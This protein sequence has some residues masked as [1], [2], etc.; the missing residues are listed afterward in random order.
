[1]K[2]ERTIL[3]AIVFAGFAT[4]AVAIWLLRP[5]F[6]GWFNHS[7]YYWVQVRGLLQDG[8]LP[9]ADLPFLFH[10]YRGVAALYHLLGLEIASAIVNSTRSVMSI[11]PALIAIPAYGLIKGI[12]QDRPLTFRLWTLVAVSAFLPLTFSHM[13][14]LLQKN[15]L[16]LFFLGGLLF[17]TLR[18]LRLRS[19]RSLIACLA[20]FLLIAVTHLGTLAVTLLFVL[21][22]VSAFLF[23]KANPRQIAGWLGLL[24]VCSGSG[25][26]AVYLLDA[27]AFQRILLYARSSLPGSLI[28]NLFSSDPLVRRPMAFLGIIIPLGMCLFLLWVYRKRRS[29]LAMPDRIFWLGS[30]LFAYILVLPLFDLDLVPR[31]I[32]FLPLPAMVILN[33]CLRFQAK[34]RL[35]IVLVVLASVGTA[36]MV[37]GETMELLFRSPDKRAI[38]REL[39]DLKDQ[40]QLTENDF[41]L[42]R[43]GVNPICNWFLGTKSGLITAVHRDD[44]E[45][46]DRFFVLNPA[47]GSMASAPTRSGDGTGPVLPSQ[48]KAYV[49]MRSDVPLPVGIRPLVETEHLSFY[50]L[51]SMPETWQFDGDGNWMATIPDSGQPTRSDND[52]QLAR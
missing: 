24:L 11:V 43:Y 45:S 27:G 1:M 40:Y 29:S 31:F 20:L 48:K 36:V 21:A 32:L 42:T 51:R 10:L 52:S 12:H 5:E 37:A 4:R 30:T 47:R 26:I 9:Y 33:Y 49:A 41:V 6:V 39:L 22:L 46:Y 2:R 7:Y 15:C 38:H 13:P 19:L 8:Q 25:L 16:G 50:R 14:E 34:G 35:G 44:I 23:E 17:T 18:Y 3:A 28:G